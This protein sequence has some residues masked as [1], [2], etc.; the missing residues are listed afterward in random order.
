MFSWELIKDISIEDFFLSFQPDD[1]SSFIALGESLIKLLALPVGGDVSDANIIRKELNMPIDLSERNNSNKVLQK[2]ARFTSEYGDIYTV[3]S[4]SD[5]KAYANALFDVNLRGNN[6]NPHS[7]VLFQHLKDSTDPPVTTLKIAFEQLLKKHKSLTN[8]INEAYALGMRFPGN[9]D[10]NKQ[11]GGGVGGKRVLDITADDKKIE[12]EPKI[13]KQICQNCGIQGHTRESC[14]IEECPY[15]NKDDCAYAKSSAWEKC[16]AKFSKAI[17]I[18][19]YPRCPNPTFLRKLKDSLSLVK[20]DANPNVNK[21]Q[22]NNCCSNLNY[23]S[24][25]NQCYNCNVVVKNKNDE[26]MALMSTNISQFLNYMEIIIPNRLQEKNQEDRLNLEIRSSEDKVPTMALIDTGALHGN[27]GGS[28]VS[29]LGLSV[30]K[31]NLNKQICSPINNQCVPCSDTVIVSAYIYDENKI[32]KVSI[33]L[34]LKILSSLDDK[35]YGLIIGLPTIKRYNLTQIFKSQFNDNISSKLANPIG[36]NILLSEGN[37]SRKRTSPEKQ[38]ISYSL[39]NKSA[40]FF[41]EQ[42]GG[43]VRVVPRKRSPL[44]RHHTRTRAVKTQSIL[45]FDKDKDNLSNLLE[46]NNLKIRNSNRRAHKY[47]EDEEVIQSDYWD[48]AWMKDDDKTEEEEDFIELIVSKIISTDASFIIEARKFLKRYKDLFSRKLNT[49]P[50]KLDPLEIEVDSKKFKVSA[51]QG[52]PRMMTS[53]KE[54]HIKKFIEEGLRSK[55]I[56]PSN[57]AYY[58]QVHLVH[59]P[60]P[61]PIDKSAPCGPRKWRTTIDYRKFNKCITTQHWPLPNISNM[62]QRI[63]TRKPKYFAKLDMT[64]GYWQAPLA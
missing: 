24:H 57:A 52:P 3:S 29:R 26:C 4:V 9:F 58:S 28:W 38:S 32:N 16:K 56:R 23:S 61:E 2:I 10:V 48:D 17:P 12:K 54:Q 21:Q 46:D 22:G 60:S 5:Q 36:G 45:L 15:T 62:I 37:A 20:T 42:K 1:L 55:V 51:N 41:N 59:K 27:Y 40:N 34:E 44:P 31:N 19:G 8:Y 25:S 14:G 13:P 11:G 39:L 6:V 7:K 64:S 43:C 30:L 33:E 49:I 50:A 18:L 47:E 63:G 53:E 35:E